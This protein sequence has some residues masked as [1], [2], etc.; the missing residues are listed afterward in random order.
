MVDIQSATAENR[1]GK[2]KKERKKTLQLQN[3]I[4]CPIGRPQQDYM[5]IKHTTVNINKFTNILHVKD[6]PDGSSI[7]HDLENIAN[8]LYAVTGFTSGLHF[9]VDNR[10]HHI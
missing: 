1:P 10:V 4:A 6:M 7:G 8:I 5:D 9:S 2:K 3:I